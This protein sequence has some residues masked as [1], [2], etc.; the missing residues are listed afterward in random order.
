MNNKFYVYAL[1]D[2]RNDII[3]YIGKGSGARYKTHS[4]EKSKNIT[5]LN[6]F[7]RIK[8]IHDAKLEVKTEILFPYLNEEDAFELEKI[9][10]YRLGRK[11]L[12]EGKLVNVVPGGNW[13]PGDSIF[14]NEKIDGNFDTNKLD[15]V[16]LERF[17]S[18]EKVSDFSYWE[19]PLKSM[20]I[21][22]YNQKGEL[23][24]ID[25]IDCIFR[26][27]SSMNFQIFAALRNEDLPITDSTYIYSTRPYSNLYFSPKLTLPAYHFF[28]SEFCKKFD[29]FEKE[30]EDFEIDFVHNGVVRLRASRKD[31][32][33]TFCSFRKDGSKKHRR[34]I[35]EI[36]NNRECVEWSQQGEIMKDVGFV[37]GEINDYAKF[38]KNGNIKTSYVY[39]Y[40][41]L[42]ESRSYYESGILKDCKKYFNEG[43]II[44][45]TGFY[46]NGD[47]SFKYSNDGISI[48]YEKYNSLGELIEVYDPQKGYVNYNNEGSLVGIF[49]ERKSTFMDNHNILK[50]HIFTPKVGKMTKV[51]KE[52]REDD[53]DWAKFMEIVENPEHPPQ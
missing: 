46:E 11:C 8:K 37:E 50:P 15:F 6:K 42:A 35:D 39:S 36:T 32:K 4:K 34:I 47:I 53:E 26:N 20:K 28:D 19:E 51:L 48:K 13:K 29:S 31:G 23:I 3:F 49:N 5:N 25:C 33:L 12:K 16:A 38:Y 52:K 9:M 14:Y 2:P 30:E 40:N 17:K 41:R 24:S 10:I 22:K 7:S 27:L 45:R 44:L 18:F 1:I 21:F 43:K